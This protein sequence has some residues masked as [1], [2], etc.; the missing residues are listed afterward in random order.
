MRIAGA[1]IPV[2][3]DIVAN[4]KTIK[5]SIDWASENNC[6]FLVTPEGSLS[7]YYPQAIM[8]AEA[9]EGLMAVLSEGVPRENLGLNS[10]S[11]I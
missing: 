6:D 2:T 8:R 5:E 3:R 4:T 10:K 11:G 7:G 9:N 1:Q